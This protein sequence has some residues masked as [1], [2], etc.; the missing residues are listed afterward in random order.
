MQHRR[1]NPAGQSL[2]R[3][4]PVVFIMLPPLENFI[5]KLYRICIN[6]PSARLDLSQQPNAIS[7]KKNVAVG[8]V[9]VGERKDHE[10]TM[11]TA[12]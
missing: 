2:S 11:P 8:A 10:R 9:L 7:C 3:G 12:V 6:A 4:V 5:G 1:D